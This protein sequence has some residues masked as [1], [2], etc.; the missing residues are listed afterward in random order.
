MKAKEYLTQ[1]ASYD[2]L[3]ECLMYERK[4]WEETK[5]RVLGVT[6]SWGE[7]VIING[8]LQNVEKVQKSM[9]TNS[10]VEG[11]VMQYV[12]I[13]LKYARDIQKLI[14]EREQI[15]N[16]IKQLQ[17]E[18]ARFLHFVYVQHQNLNAVALAFGK[19]YSWATTIHGKALAEVQKILDFREKMERERLHRNLERFKECQ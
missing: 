9:S 7:S 17:P 8:E 15:I 14:D 18:Y 2:N 5:N 19:S 11:A 3:I 16:T 6:S 1:I 12:D 4:A 10:P 13:D